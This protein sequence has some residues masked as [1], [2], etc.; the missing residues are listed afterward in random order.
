MSALEDEIKVEVNNKSKLLSKILNI[1][2]F[3]FARN[4]DEVFPNKSMHLNLETRRPDESIIGNLGPTW[5]SSNL[6]FRNTLKEINFRIVRKMKS[7]PILKRSMENKSQ[8]YFD[9]QKFLIKFSVLEGYLNY[10]DGNK[11]PYEFASIDKKEI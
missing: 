1:E 10:L 5:S 7:E 9:K 6:T 11:S 8:Y 4:R 2:I 3:F